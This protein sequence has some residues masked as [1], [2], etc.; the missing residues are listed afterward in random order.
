MNKHLPTI[1]V[2]VSNDRTQQ[3]AET[4][5]LVA[6][7]TIDEHYEFLL[8][9][10]NNKLSLRWKT[11]KQVAWLC[12][13][14]LEGALAHRQKQPRNKEAI[15]KAVGL[16][17]NYRPTVI[18]TT[19][20]LGRDAFILAS[21]GCDVTLIEKNPIIKTLLDDGLNR[22]LAKQ[23][24]KMHLLEGDAMDV[25]NVITLEQ[26]ADVI[27][28]DPLFPPRN[29]T[30]LVKKD[31]QILQRLCLITPLPQ[32]ERE[33]NGDANLLEIALRCATKRV[34]VKR[35]DYAG[36]LSERPV[37][38]SIKTPHHRFDIYRNVDHDSLTP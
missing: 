34:V 22:L 35:P 11:E 33:P 21:A 3:L 2:I 16:K 9:E 32:G 37:D 5:N 17:G 4:L 28:L 6:L 27:Y 30:A 31:M 15:I 36:P 19:A 25:L 12:I 38:F 26:K 18:D 1:A 24:L 10:Q 14:F 7:T 20:G 23:N 29:K 13:D 8:L